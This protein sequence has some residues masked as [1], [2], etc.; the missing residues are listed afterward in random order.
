MRTK[1]AQAWQRWASA[2]PKSGGNA[3]ARDPARPADAAA[4]LAVRRVDGARR[5]H[6]LVATTSRYS[7][8]M[9]TLPSVAW[10]NWSTSSSSWVISAL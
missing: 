3:D 2:R 6:G 5:H 4:G 1:V 9:A 10:L 7:T 8:S